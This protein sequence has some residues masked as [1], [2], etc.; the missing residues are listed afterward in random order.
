MALNLHITPEGDDNTNYG[1]TPEEFK[2][3]F[4]SLCEFDEKEFP[5]KYERKQISQEE[6]I[7]DLRK[8]NRAWQSEYR[9]A[10]GEVERLKQERDS[11][12]RQL[13]GLRE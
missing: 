11:L 2:K 3:A 13:E 9:A 1:M 12:T 7:E 8:D 5:N 10:R 4:R 6:I